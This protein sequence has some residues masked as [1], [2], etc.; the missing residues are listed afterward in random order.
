MDYQNVLSNEFRD[1]DLIARKEKEKY[2]SA[3]PFPH[4]TI[5]NFFSNDFLSQVLNDF[6][7][8]SKLHATQNYNNQN[9]IKFANNKYDNFS[10]K[11]KFFFDFLNSGTFL[12][13]LQ[14]LTLIKETLV[15]DNFFVKLF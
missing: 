1:L 8:L 11:I 6:P 13:F 9:E 14:S 10:D 7:D 15:S 12:Y 4:I 2:I 3:Y 5:K